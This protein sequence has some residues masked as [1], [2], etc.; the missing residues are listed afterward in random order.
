MQ[1]AR[2]TDQGFASCHLRKLLARGS[3]Q[4]PMLLSNRARRQLNP[5]AIC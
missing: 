1:P 4:P 2:L 3:R 5:R